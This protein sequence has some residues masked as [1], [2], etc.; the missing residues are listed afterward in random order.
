MTTRAD[1]ATAVLTVAQMAE[2]DRLAIAAGIASLD[3]MER[4]GAAVAAAIAER[5]S[6]RPVIVLCG[7]GNNG[8][9]G[10]V[11]A[12]LLAALG[13]PVGVAL[14]GKMDRLMGDARA[15][16]LRWT[17]PIKPLEPASLENAELVI[18]ALFGAGLNGALAGASARVLAAAA[19]HHIP[20][21]AIDMPSGVMGDT[22]ASLGAV[23]AELTVTFFRKKPGHLLLPGKQLC[24][25][26]IVADIGTPPDVL[27]TIAPKCFENGPSFWIGSLPGIAADSNKFTRGHA[28]LWGGYPA[29]GAA[30]LAARAAAR[31][32]AGLITIAVD[33]MALPIYAAALTSIMVRPVA[34]PDDMD[35]LLQDRRLTAL[36]IGPGAGLANATRDRV[37]AMLATSRP[38]V[39]DA[40]ALT[41]FQNDA[42]LLWKAIASA[43]PG[44]CVLTPHEG[45]FARLFDAKGD[46]LS[47]ARRAARSSS[48]TVILKGS[49]TI[50]AA[51]GGKAIIN[52]NA[53]PSLA[54]GG[55]GDVLA[56]IVLG[57]L[58][59]GMPPFHAAAAAVW[60]HGAAATAFGMGLMA[61]DLPDCLPGV[62]SQ[63]HAQFSTSLHRQGYWQRLEA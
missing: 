38:V 28:L 58:A 29:T 52:N 10:L 23:A 54:T 3:L 45:E 44:T 19:A 56:G 40:D 59:Q 7:P 4:A 61:E 11:A 22:G 34:C 6:R 16:A 63:L 8:G 49:D 27:D 21:V 62:L 25:E 2:A 30:R 32:G 53:P 9:D 1:S 13:W 55:S 41:V 51:P 20:I 48:A 50:I 37:L 42:A 33:E 60:L 17:G 24:G 5:W 39:L 47:R 26:V 46:K 31:A 15:N 36:L 57:L 18:D 35:N 14:C 43:R 12:R